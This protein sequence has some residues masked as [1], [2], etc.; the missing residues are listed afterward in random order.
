[1]GRLTIA[2]A[3]DRNSSHLPR[4]KKGD[5]VSLEIIKKWRKRDKVGEEFSG[6]VDITPRRMPSGAVMLRLKLDNGRLMWFPASPTYIS[7][8]VV[9][10]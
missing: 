5:Y 4:V 6:E 8:E 7:M 2:L 3:R 10:R 1:M 9:E